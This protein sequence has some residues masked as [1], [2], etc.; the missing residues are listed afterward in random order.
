MIAQYNCYTDDVCNNLDDNTRELAKLEQSAE[1]QKEIIELYK[2]AGELLAD[3]ENTLL[4]FTPIIGDAKAFAEAEDVIDYTIASVGLIPGVGDAVVQLLK[5]AKAA[6]KVGDK[7]KAI[8]LAQEAQDKLNALDVGSANKA[9]NTAGKGS[10]G[11]INTTQTGNVSTSSVKV[12]IANDFIKNPQS[13]WGKSAD[14]IAKDFQAAGYQVNVR[15][16]SRGSGQA[17]IIEVKGHPEISQV[18]IHPGGGR[19]GGSYYKVST[20]TQG[21]VKV[22][23]SNTYKPSAGEKATIINKPKE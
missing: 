9:S 16:S 2:E 14:D 5:E 22:V 17:V 6:L 19:H 13:I 7:K 18:Q 21:T 15:Q 1:I 23:D 10:T 11:T 3:I 20:T 12:N 8:E 4:D